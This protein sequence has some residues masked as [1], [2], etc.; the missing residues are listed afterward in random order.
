MLKLHIF[1]S[2]IAAAVSV[3]DNR[4]Y[5]SVTTG[6]A[7]TNTNAAAGKPVANAIFID[8]L[9]FEMISPV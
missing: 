1:I 5:N 2:L 8:V 7:K 4:G 6:S 9:L 3:A